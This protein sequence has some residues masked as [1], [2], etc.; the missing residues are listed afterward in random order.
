MK[1]SKIGKLI[2]ILFLFVNTIIA[3]E[4]SFTI[5][6]DLSGDEINLIVKSMKA[7]DLEQPISDQKNKS[8]LSINETIEKFALVDA[9]MITENRVFFVDISDPYSFLKS[10]ILLEYWFSYNATKFFIVV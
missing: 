3:Q 2:I 10:Y 6:H 7:I 5:I 4:R 1:D 8:I 9:K